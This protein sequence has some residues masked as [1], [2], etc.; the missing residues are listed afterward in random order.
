MSAL[1][2][3]GLLVAHRPIV[4]DTQ[5]ACGILPLSPCEERA[6]REPERGGIDKS[7]LLSPAL[8]SF[9]E[10]ERERKC[11][12]AL[13]PNLLPNTTDFQ[14]AVSPNWIRQTLASVPRVARSQ[15]LAECNSAI[16]RSAAMLLPKRTA[17]VVEDPAAACRKGAVLRLVLRTPRSEQSSLLATILGETDRVPLCDTPTASLRLGGRHL[18]C[19]VCLLLSLSSRTLAVSVPIRFAGHNAELVLSEI[20]E[21]TLR[22]ELNQIDEQGRLHPPSPSTVLVPF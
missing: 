16:P 4:F 1:S 20:R 11:G 22:I 14:S 7:R 10:E 21:R 6:G 18:L 2:R 12:C 17:T 3:I 13:K 9:F 8:S 19:L 15:H 5:N